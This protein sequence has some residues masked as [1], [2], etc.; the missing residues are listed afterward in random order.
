[1]TKAAGTVD[2]I[3]SAAISMAVD[4]ISNTALKLGLI[5]VLGGGRFRALAGLGLIAFAAVSALLLFLR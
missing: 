5:V 4:T 1:M 2:Q 3:P